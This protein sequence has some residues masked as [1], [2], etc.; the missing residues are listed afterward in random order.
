MKIKKIIIALLLCFLPIASFAQ[1]V[2]ETLPAWEE[3]Y[4]DIH[5]INTGCGECA[6]IILPDGTTMLI[7]A[8]ENKAGNPRH[9][10]PKPN[11]G[12]TQVNGSLI[13]SKRWHLFKS[14][15]WIMP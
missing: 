2:G 11:A 6:Y 9:V 12:R 7:D 1:K 5:H 15:N 13:I 8:G 14:K 3:G 10:L 4:M